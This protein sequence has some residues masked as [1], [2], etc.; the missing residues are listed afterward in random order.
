MKTKRPLDSWKSHFEQWRLQKQ[1]DELGH[2]VASTGAY[3]EKV[4]MPG[5]GKTNCIGAFF[6]LPKRR[7]SHMQLKRD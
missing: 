5:I 1:V 3:E 7:G 6:E 2:G 4:L